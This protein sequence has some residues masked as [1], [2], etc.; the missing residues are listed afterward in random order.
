MSH[1]P[2][3]LRARF[4]QIGFGHGGT[5]APAAFLNR[6]AFPRVHG[7]GPGPPERP[8]GFIGVPRVCARLYTHASPRTAPL[9]EA[10]AA[11]VPGPVRRA[12]APL[13]RRRVETLLRRRS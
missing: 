6:C 9:A 5:T 13:P 10:P 7:I 1:A 4:L 3:A 11:R 2:G 12:A 8:C